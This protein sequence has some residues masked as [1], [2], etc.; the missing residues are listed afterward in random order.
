VS[1]GAGSGRRCRSETILSS[2]HRSAG[3]RLDPF[4]C[5]TIPPDRPMGS[6]RVLDVR[7]RPDPPGC[8]QN[9]PLVEALIDLTVTSVRA[10][11]DPNFHIIAGHDRPARRRAIRAS[12]SSRQTGRC[13]SRGRTT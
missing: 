12:L 4:S 9:W 2:T 8:A 5:A 3:P 11:T 1:R 7:N 13:R 10:Q 6:L